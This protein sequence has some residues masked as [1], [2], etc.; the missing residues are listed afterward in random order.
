MAPR[1]LRYS[2]L[3][4]CLFSSLAEAQLPIFKIE[5]DTT[6]T[7]AVA[8]DSVANDPAYLSAVDGLQIRSTIDILKNIWAYGLE[9]RAY[10]DDRLEERLGREK[11]FNA[12]ARVVLKQNFLRALQDLTQ[13]VIN[14][15]TLASSDIKFKRKPFLPAT[16]LRNLI[17]SAGGD[18]ETV[19]EWMSPQNQP[20]RTLREAMYRL[21]P[22][23]RRGGW[24]NLRS[25]NIPLQYG[26]QHPSILGIKQRLSDLGHQI[27][28][29]NDLF[30]EDLQ[31]AIYDVQMQLKMKPDGVI[32]PGGRTWQYLTT[33]AEN[34]LNQ[35]RADMEK[36]RWLPS[37]LEARHIFVNLAFST[38]VLQDK[39]GPQPRTIFFKTINGRP[40]RKTPMMRDRI[41]YLILNPAW[42]VPPTVFLEDKV[43]LIRGLPDQN[44]IRDYF[45][46]N[47]F[48]VVTSDLQTTLD[49]ATIDWGGI[50]SA[51]VPF[52]IRQRPNYYNALGV[53]KF[54][55]TNPESIYLHDTNERHRFDEFNRQVSS[56]CVR[57]QRPMD[58]AEYLLEGTQWTR[59]AIE[60]FVV[61]PGQSGAVETKVN[62]N[63]P[64][65]V[66]LVSQTTSVNDNGLIRFAE[67]TYEQNSVIMY[68]MAQAEVQPF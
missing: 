5:P 11:L 30:D 6:V 59:E 18:A 10:M 56:G 60:N 54:M 67:D 26:V 45:A 47:N 4:V 24:G 22:I 36:L 34:R 48:D 12:R 21:Y 58:L 64:I 1:F 7:N 20:Y 68:L 19:M 25:A 37:Q 61:K 16:Q 50:K 43:E 9:P 23:V 40:T 15:E 3:S 44:A 17:N 33:S 53:V 2:V 13:G 27:T 8:S 14:P 66:Y 55:M 39:T 29:M 52:Y 63:N 41:T 65:P 49:P 38:F 32:S 62:I 46:S 57:L 31:I 35:I 42:V 28:R 51:D